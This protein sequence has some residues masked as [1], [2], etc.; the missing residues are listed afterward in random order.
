MNMLYWD[1]S[2]NRGGGSGKIFMIGAACLITITCLIVF[3]Y[4]EDDYADD[5]NTLEHY[6]GWILGTTNVWAGLSYLLAY[7]YEKG[8]LND[9]K[10]KFWWWVRLY[11]RLGHV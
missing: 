9:S 8:Y 10:L 1:Y 11:M 6:Y 5:V 2:P 3:Y 4:G 7:W